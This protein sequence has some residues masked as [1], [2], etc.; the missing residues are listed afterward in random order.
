[1]KNKL[2]DYLG[3]ISLF[4][5]ILTAAIALTILAVPLYQF[6]LNHLDI[7]ERVGMS[8]DQIMDNYYALLEYLHFPWV[9]TLVLPDFPVSASGAFHFYEVKILFYINYGALLVSGIMSFFYLRRLNRLNGFWRL[10]NPFK[11]AIFVP[12]VLLFILAIDFD[13]MFLIFHEILFNNDAWVFNPATDPIITV[14]PQ[15]FFMYCFILAF[16]LIEGS[17]IGGYFLSKKKKKY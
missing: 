11:I 17:F 16:T 1:M 13:F 7:P 8:F 15:E 4:V 5:F 9:D 10:V 6:A 3:I 2:R 14:L 12:F